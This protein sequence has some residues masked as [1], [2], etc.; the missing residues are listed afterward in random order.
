MYDRQH[1]DYLNWIQKIN[2]LYCTYANGLI[3]YAQEIAA[4]TERYW[5]PIKAAKKPIFHHKWYND[6]ADYGN[7]KEWK[8]KFND[9]KAFNKLRKK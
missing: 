9:E 3:A 4:R 5:C 1:L 8:E 2:C 7:P 6:F